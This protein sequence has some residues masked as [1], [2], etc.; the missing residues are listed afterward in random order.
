MSDGTI[1]VHFDVLRRLLF[2]TEIEV[3]SRF[4][5]VSEIASEPEKGKGS[6]YEARERTRAVLGD[7]Y[8]EPVG[9]MMRIRSQVEAH[10]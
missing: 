7:K 4:P 10:P 8:F 1:A 9:I 5:V 2:E 3:Q 6:D